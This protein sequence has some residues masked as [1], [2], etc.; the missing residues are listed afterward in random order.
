MYLIFPFINLITNKLNQKQFLYLLV[1]LFFII[2]VFSPLNSIVEN[3]N[4]IIYVLTWWIFIYLTGAY[5]KLYPK[6]FNNKI[7]NI[8]GIIICL[9]VKILA[10][11]WKLSS[12][13]EERNNYITYFLSVFIFIFFKNLNI[14]QNKFINLIAST[15]LGVYML[16]E[17]SMNTII[18]QEWIKIQTFV[19]SNYFWL[20]IILSVLLVFVITSIIDIARQ[21]LLEKPLFENLGNNS[22]F[23]KFFPYEEQ[24]Y[25]AD[26]K[27]KYLYLHI[28][29]I[30]IIATL[31]KFFIQT[32]YI[33]CAFI[34]GFIIYLI[35]FKIVLKITKNIKTKIKLQQK[36]KN[37]YSQKH[38]NKFIVYF[39]TNFYFLSLSMFLLFNC[40]NSI[41]AVLHIK[42]KFNNW[43]AVINKFF[44]VNHF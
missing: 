15:T 4:E 40:V 44:V 16:H 33:T 5:I 38:K 17:N 14:K 36:N 34:L 28:F 20:A 6:S 22:K 10:S 9:A 37:L 26:I 21:Y 42:Q 24:I 1:V 27:T 2:C 39:I 7:I 25:Q 8:I 30:V 19:E 29:A 12:F 43:L 23:D 35:L 11:Y 18:W 3:Q 13:F 32:E 41:V 31:S